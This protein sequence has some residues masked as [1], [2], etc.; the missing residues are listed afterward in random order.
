M[1]FNIILYGSE[2][3]TIKFFQY[4][5]DM[6]PIASKKIELLLNEKVHDNGFIIDPEFPFLAQV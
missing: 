6:E 4:G 5:K 3:L 2:N 1:W